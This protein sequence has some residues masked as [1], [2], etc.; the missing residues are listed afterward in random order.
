MADTI[1]IM[2]PVPVGTTF[3]EGVQILMMYAGWKQSV[4]EVLR[5]DTEQEVILYRSDAIRIQVQEEGLDDTTDS[6]VIHAVFDSLCGVIILNTS[7]EQEEEL[8]S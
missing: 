7:V 1:P 2:V 5:E 6:S 3:E 4:V 8:P